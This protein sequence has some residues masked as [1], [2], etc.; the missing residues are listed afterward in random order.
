MECPV[1]GC[2]VDE[3]ADGFV[4]ACGCCGVIWLVAGDHQTLDHLLVGA[5]G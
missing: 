5:E 3:S 1:C 2:P 4:A